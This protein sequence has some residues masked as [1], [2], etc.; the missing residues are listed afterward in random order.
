M[1]DLA[2]YRAIRDLEGTPEPLGADPVERALPAGAART[3]VVQQHAAKGMHWDLRLEIGGVLASWAV[4]KGPSLD[5]KDKR[6]AI[7]TEDHPIE[8]ADFEG[9]IPQGNYG[10]GAMILWDRGAYRT[11]DGVPP[12]EGLE[13]GKLDL[14]LEGHKLR[15]RFA[16][17]RTKGEDGRSWLLLHKGEAREDIGELGPASVLSGLPVE[18]LSEGGSRAE[19]VMGGLQ[20]L[21]APPWKGDVR[22][23]RPMLAGGADAPFSRPGWLFELKYDGARVIA[24]RSG[25]RVTLYSRSGRDATATYP[26]LALAVRHLPLDDF[27]IDGEVVSLA[28]DGR[29][30]FERLQKRFVQSDPEAIRRLRVES[31]VVYYAFDLLEASG[32]DLRSA[33]LVE[34]KKILALFTPRL[35]FVR[36]AD[37][38]EGDGDALYEAASEHGLEGV[39]A[40]RA[41]ARYATGRRSKNWLKIKVPR[42][43]L[44]AIVGYVPGK[45]ARRALGSLM[46]AWQRDNAF[47]YV[48]NAGSGLDE[49][50]IAELL[51]RLEEAAVDG[52]AFLGVP[53]PLPRGA[54][55][56]RP[57]LVCE[58]RYTE[59]TSAGLL[60]HPVFL[61]LRPD[62][63]PEDCV[64][65]VESGATAE[66]AIVAPASEPRL[67]LTRLD[68]VF[69]PIEGYTK[70]D[71]LAYYKSVWPWL[72][73]YLRDRPVVLTRY[74]DGVEG[75]NFY[76]KNAPEFTPAWVEREQIEGTDYFIC[77]E[78]RT[79]LYVI[80]SGAIPLHVWSARRDRLDKPDWLILDL[81][82]KRAPFLHVVLVA[83]HIHRLLA[84]LGVPHFVKTSGQDGLHVM[85][86]LA[87]QLDHAD[88]K[89]L[90]EVLARVVC[91]DLPEI[92]T[93]ARPL[94]ARGDKVYVD[95]LQNGRGKLIAAPFSV[96]PR[97]HAPVSMPLTWPQVSSRL[98]PTRWTLATA[99]RRLRRSGDPLRP[100]LD[101]S[102]DVET[103]LTALERL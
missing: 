99:P 78:L 12:Q 60:R 39:V 15:G 33:P 2:R 34:R 52:P 96:R 70:G 102:L 67:K 75:K 51:E 79:L 47:V 6:L 13:R 85:L 54:V 38:V 87:A 36:F 71:L 46:L 17:V 5:P 69:W 24:A 92:A 30:S 83:R 7:R 66:V 76:Q 82:P 18:E 95:F 80:N 57:D 14:H 40:K 35:G 94:A 3:F 43:S 25:E 22:R 68:K 32:R 50:T 62:R 28:E 45:G 77:N 10:A 84:D 74:P 8:Y 61:G 97:A 20:R 81:D 72:A 58:V 55:Y 21:R 44:F 64:S 9:I 31:P 63:S 26:E 1:S 86:P 37:H 11:V 41:D 27:V 73:P 90:A 16:L 59:V 56:T 100:I 23:L 4:P 101:E 91:A 103:L 88:A 65:P 49:S 42:S 53:D 29:S 98:D 93:V 19:Q 89:L 48:G